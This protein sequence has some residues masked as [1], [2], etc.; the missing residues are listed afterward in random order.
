MYDYILSKPNHYIRTQVVVKR[1]VTVYR[2]GKEWP[3][4]IAC[5]RELRLVKSQASS[6]GLVL[7]CFSCCVCLS[8]EPHLYV[9]LGSRGC[10]L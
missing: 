5:D 1:S 6:P 7:L 3:N 4:S 8:V 9:R 2:N 10:L